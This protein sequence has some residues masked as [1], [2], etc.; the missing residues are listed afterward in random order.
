MKLPANLQALHIYLLSKASSYII[1][2]WLSVNFGPFQYIE[3]GALRWWSHVPQCRCLSAQTHTAAAHRN[4]EVPLSSGSV[5]H[6]HLFA[7]H[8]SSTPSLVFILSYTPCLL[9]SP[10]VPLHQYVCVC[11]FDPRFFQG[12]SSS[13]CIVGLCALAI[14]SLLW[15]GKVLRDSCGPDPVKDSSR[16]RCAMGKQQN[17]NTANYDPDR[18]AELQ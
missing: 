16:S 10:P 13:S 15:S 1:W 3:S 2:H 11:V 6:T 5:T 18:P 8:I 4:T 7:L 12:C 17:T 9:Q 14:G